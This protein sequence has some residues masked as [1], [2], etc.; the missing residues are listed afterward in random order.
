MPREDCKRIVKEPR[1][2][3]CIRHRIN[4]RR[5]S[6]TNLKIRCFQTKNALKLKQRKMQRLQKKIF[7]LLY[8]IN[9]SIFFQTNYF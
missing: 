4:L 6:K 2:N 7:L 8:A 1:C 3:K 5:Q 9:R